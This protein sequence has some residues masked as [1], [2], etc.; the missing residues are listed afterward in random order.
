M[1]PGYYAV[2]RLAG[3]QPRVLGSRAT[4]TVPQPGGARGRSLICCLPTFE[5]ARLGEVLDVTIRAH[6]LGPGST[7]R[8]EDICQTT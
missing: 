4:Y 1:L 6:H 3:R 5:P 8:Q 2:S 7:S